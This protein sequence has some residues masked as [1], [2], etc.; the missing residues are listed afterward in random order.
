MDKYNCSTCGKELKSM[1]HICHHCHPIDY[2]DPRVK[3]DLETNC[4]IPRP[5]PKTD[6]YQCSKC[7]MTGTDVELMNKH[8]TMCA[9]ENILVIKKHG[10]DMRSRVDQVED[11]CGS[12][13]FL[14]FYF[15]SEGNINYSWG[16]GMS[17]AQMA[18]MSQILKMMVDDNFR[19]T[20]KWERD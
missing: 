10:P 18:Y 11:V 7:G 20:I 2:N 1:I 9:N 13:N 3:M 16:E 19:S 14:L 17:N 6:N 15:N 8:L 4:S 5:S 12:R